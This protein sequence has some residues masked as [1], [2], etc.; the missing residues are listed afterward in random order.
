MITSMKAWPASKAHGLDIGHISRHRSHNLRYRS[1]GLG[2]R[3]HCPDISFQL[4]IRQWSHGL[5]KSHIV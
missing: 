4:V 2:Y 5:D 1:H 3:S